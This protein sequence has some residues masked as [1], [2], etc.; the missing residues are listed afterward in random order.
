[1]GELFKVAAFAH[2]S[3]GTPPAFE[4]SMS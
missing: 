2:P 4:V 1:M 3:I